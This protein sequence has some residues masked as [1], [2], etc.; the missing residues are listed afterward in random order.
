MN[1]T[2]LDKHEI[3]FNNLIKFNGQCIVCIERELWNC[4]L[5]D[6]TKF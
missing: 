2:K 1:S 4:I 5:K 3:A 6:L